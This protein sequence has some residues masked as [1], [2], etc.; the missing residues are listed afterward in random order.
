MSAF[1]NRELYDE[2]EY[3]VLCDFLLS[4]FRYK[5]KTEKNYAYDFNIFRKYI[6]KSIFNVDSAACEAYIKN[7]NKAYPSCQAPATIERIYSQLHRLYE[8]LCEQNKVKENPFNA[9]EKPA[10]DR[11]ISKDR[12][13]SFEEAESLLN[14]AKELELR[15]CAMLQLLFTTGLKINDFVSLNWNNIIC[16]SKGEL[17]LY[18][19]KYNKPYYNKLHKDVIHM[20]LQYRESLGKPQTIAASESDAIFIN[21]RGARISQNWVRMVIRDAC[22]M[23]G[24]KAHSPSSIRNSLGAFMLTFGVTPTEVAEVMGYSD[25]FLTTRLPIVLPKRQDY[26]HFNIKGVS[27]V[28]QGNEHESE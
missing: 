20:L 14:A 2:D 16:D 17:G 13:L 12:V 7:T 4:H 21:A 26:L 27:N 11:S 19:Q 18:I 23:A 9:V 1:L 22:M 3:R 10:V 24:I 8:Y 5:P 6:N 28:I 25:T 15:D